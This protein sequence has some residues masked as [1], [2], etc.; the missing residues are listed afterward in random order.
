MDNRFRWVKFF[1]DEIE[2]PH[3]E[4]MLGGKGASLHEMTTLGLNVPYG[5]TLTTEAWRIA[6]ENGNSLPN[7]IWDEVQRGIKGIEIKKNK[8][9]GEISDTEKMKLLTVSIR[10]GSEY[11]MPGLMS[12]I[13]NVGLNDTNLDFFKKQVG[14]RCALDCYLSLIRLYSVIVDKVKSQRFQD[15][16]QSFR[17]QNNLSNDEELEIQH[18]Q[19]LIGIYKKIVISET[20]H[21][22]EQ[23]VQ[24]Q[25]K[26]GILA[27][28][29]S[30][31]NKGAI[32]YRNTHGIPH[33]IGTAV[34]VQIMA[35]GNKNKNSGAAV[36]F[37]RNRLTG[38]TGIDGSVVINN[39]GEDV[40][41]GTKL[42][43]PITE[44]K[45]S[46]A[47][48]VKE[49]ETNLIMLEKRYRCPVDVELTWED[50]K[51][52][53]LQA[54][55][56]QM[57]P[58][59]AIKS[60]IDLL[61]EGAFNKNEDA[62][63][64]IS[65]NQIQTVQESRFKEKKKINAQFVF[66]G[67]PL[68]TGVG[69]GHAYFDVPS[70][71][72]A[73]AEGKKVILICNHFDPNDIELITGIYSEE[74]DIKRLQ[75]IITAKGSPSSH[76]G[77]VMSA[78]VPP[79][80][81][82][83][84]CASILEINHTNKNSSYM[85][86]GNNQNIK[87]EIVIKQDEI[88]SMDSYTGEVFFGK[89]EIAEKP[90]FS[91]EIKHFINQWENYFGKR[92]YWTNFLFTD[93]GEA[94]QYK[95]RLKIF[96]NLRATV[97]VW[98]GSKANQ[99]AFINEIFKD[100]PMLIYTYIVKASQVS[101][102]KKIIEHTREINGSAR[103]SIWLRSDY[104][105]SLLMA[106]YTSID[107]AWGDEQTVGNFWTDANSKVSK[108]GGF[109]KWQIILDEKGEI[110]RLTEI[111]IPMDPKGKLD[112]DENGKY[113][114][115][116]VCTFRATAD[117]AIIDINL[118]NIHLRSL[119]AANENNLLQIIVK[120]N[121]HAKYNL[122]CVS[123]NFGKEHFDHDKIDHL[124]NIFRTKKNDAII[125]SIF[126][127]KILRRVNIKR[128]QEF[129]ADDLILLLLELIHSGVINEDDFKLFM[130]DHAYAVAAYVK[131]TFFD[132]W[133]SKLALPHLM[134]A[135]QEAIG[136]VLLEFQG[137]RNEKKNVA[138]IKLYGTKG[139]EEA[140]IIK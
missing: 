105:P 67:L 119:E 32:E 136:A 64:R 55:P 118:N 91:E 125:P 59:G 103:P 14:E 57:S 4:K 65:L 2:F 7:E 30:F 70:A 66:K 5:F 39:Q 26:N 83:M 25:I 76:M 53:Y 62:F 135:L 102:A 92:N 33:H 104:K 101:E 131:K 74:G 96:N 109:P 43:L 36:V 61:K 58:M 89:I 8:K 127:K 99:L 45:F 85:R 17:K 38:E 29:R 113:D 86:L 129:T 98:K 94:Q 132:D 90:T 138:W 87:E 122:G 40:V 134:W 24:S 130:K 79:M 44:L 11:S 116:F 124:L 51:I 28:F 106:P 47:D 41:A 31:N 88:I 21:K 10:S 117:A 121:M 19:D 84:G 108:W 120:P 18:L 49:I 1:D 60:T 20:G 46:R 140:G 6:N 110:H 48:L 34:N 93:C 133:W 95:T 50:D 72:K 126:A 52:Y 71:K 128:L 3:P 23:D 123:F 42:T 77:L 22:F 78:V 54:R 73:V 100:T 115:K 137:Q 114:D 112:K 9:F 111:L 80:P 27:V 107:M 69:Y 56:A 35:L 82:I 12:T 139:Q 13:L 37:S 97:A 16:E 68:C 81:G 75:G 63:F 15:A